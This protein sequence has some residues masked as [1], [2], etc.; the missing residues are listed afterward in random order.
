MKSFVKILKIIMLFVM[1]VLPF[2][3]V[4]ACGDDLVTVNLVPKK[5]GLGDNLGGTKSPVE[6]GCPLTVYY[7]QSLGQIKFENS[8]SSSVSFTYS[9]YD[10]DANLLQYGDILVNGNSIY[11][12]SLS[13][14]TE[15]PA[16][17]QIE[18]DGVI[19]EGSLDV[20]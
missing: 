12:L 16:V 1:S 13:C 19:Y 15:I 9:V 6:I 18:Y 20:E 8:C 14:M 7:T 3:P 2:T 11:V 5:K 10:V 4:L 17:I